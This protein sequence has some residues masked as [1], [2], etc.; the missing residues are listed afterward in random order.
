MSR[1]GFLAAVT[2]VA[3]S[4]H[5]RVG[6]ADPAPHDWHYVLPPAGDPFEHPPFRA[7]ALSDE[8]P[9]DVVEDVAYRGKHHRYAQ[10][11]FGSPSSVRVTVVVDEVGPGEVDLYVD[12]R[13]KRRIAAADRVDGKDFVWRLPL[14]AAYVKGEQTEKV[15]RAAVF[16]YGQVGRTLAFAAA[17]Y[18]EGTALVGGK[19]VRA[20]RVDGDANG[21]FTDPQDR[22]WLDLDGDGRFEPMSEQFLYAPVLAVG[23]SRYAVRTDEH[24]S[25][26]SLEPLHGTGTVRLA[27]RPSDRKSRVREVSATLVGRD[28]SAVSLGGTTP[29]AVVPAGEYRLAAVAVAL[30]D[31]AG[32]PRW[33]FIFSDQGRRGPPL[34]HSVAKDDTLILDPIGS[35]EL[36][37]GLG[38][39]GTVK[40]GG[41]LE[42]Q[43]QLFTE[44]GLLIV[45]C[46]RGTPAS[47]AGEE[48]FAES[49]LAGKNNRVGSARSGFL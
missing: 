44:D 25:W 9:P 24:G 11:R 17:G 26:L 35:L 8:K 12:A 2:L 4:A 16:R 31:P 41:D 14:D 33:T 15:R 42:F 5:C 49:V 28:G 3:L 45:S 20:R 39:V 1:T 48:S 38:K 36:R 6:A 29:A 27:A 13:R 40:S 10:L 22:L 21:F 19:A 46:A 34:W 30:D 7:L 47:P 23:G 43:P 37:T 18:L 32:G